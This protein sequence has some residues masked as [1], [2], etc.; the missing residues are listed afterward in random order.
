MRN[1]SGAGMNRTGIALSPLN[2]RELIVQAAR[3]VPSSEG[4]G[5]RQIAEVR[6]S[7]ADD[8]EP[9][10]TMPPPLTLKGTAEAVNE[11]ALGHRMGVLLDKL[12][13]RLAFERTAIRLYEALIAKFDPSDE[14]A[15]DGPSLEELEEIHDDELAH[16]ELIREAIVSLGGDPTAITPSADVAST[17]QMGLPHV[18]TDPRTTFAQCLDTVLTAELIDNDGWAMLIYLAEALKHDDLA[19]RFR[20]ALEQEDQHLTSIR[21]WLLEAINL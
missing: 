4:D 8:A 11:I 21:R 15:L 2:S 10:G 5:P 3:A 6:T 18:L 7:Y 9:I 16:F 12:G 17:A 1:T 19:E 13:E 14:E 20:Q